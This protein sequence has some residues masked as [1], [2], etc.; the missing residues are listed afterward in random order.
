LV[1]E[2]WH[3]KVVDPLAKTW[4]QSVDQYTNVKDWIFDW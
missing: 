3:T 4:D 2:N 1:K